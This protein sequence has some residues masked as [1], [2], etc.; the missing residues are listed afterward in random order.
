MGC[1][2]SA[3][4]LVVGPGAGER[5]EAQG[6]DGQPAAAVRHDD[7]RHA[8]R[9]GRVRR[10]LRRPGGPTARQARKTYF[11]TGTVWSSSSM[12][13]PNVMDWTFSVRVG[14]SLLG[15]DVLC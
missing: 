13:T 6:D 4:H 11:R 8:P 14:R 5:H 9:H 7:D 2:P 3:T 10:R 12:K 1:L 15:L